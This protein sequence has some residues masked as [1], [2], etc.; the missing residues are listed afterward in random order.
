[1]S[2]G[3]GY[4]LAAPLLACPRCGA[5]V[6]GAVSTPR[7]CDGCRKPFVAVLGP[8]HDRNVAAPAADP[9][10]A[11]FFLKWSLGFVSKTA[12]LGPAGMQ[13]G[14]LDPVIGLAPMNQVTIG[15]SEVASI[16]VWRTIAWGLAIAGPLCFV[17]FG[18][19]AA[20]VAADSHATV[21][22][23]AAIVAVAFFV[24]PVVLVRHA[25]GIGHLNARVVGRQGVADV[26]L[27][28]RLVVYT[29]LFRRI[30]LMA[31]PQP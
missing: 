9:R 4:A 29:E 24:I 27:D 2:G 11:T 28:R 23:V 6:T 3:P 18:I 5:P 8:L 21:R 1:M 17:P 22:I 10:A 19:L 31:P 20:F 26:R 14:M 25:V 15:W 16:T 12:V 7:A 30:G 13:C